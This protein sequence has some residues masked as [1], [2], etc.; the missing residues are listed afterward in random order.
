[1]G[2]RPARKACRDREKRHGRP[3]L[4]LAAA[5]TTHLGTFTDFRNLSI[6]VEAFL[7]LR[8]ARRHPRQ[9]FSPVI[10]R[11]RRDDETATAGSLLEAF[12][13]VNRNVYRLLSA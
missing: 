12:D 2:E 3:A 13:D 10:C 11:S 8:R 4:L 1:M 6:T 9:S 7:R 5:R